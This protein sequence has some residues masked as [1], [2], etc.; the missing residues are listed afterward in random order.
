MRRARGVPLLSLL[1]AL[2]LA[3]CSNL[4]PAGSGDGSSS[5]APALPLPETTL[6][7]VTDLRGGLEEQFTLAMEDLTGTPPESC[8]EQGSCALLVDDESPEGTLL[9]HAWH[10]D[11]AADVYAGLDSST[12]D[13]KWTLAEEEGRVGSAH[14]SRHGPVLLALTSTPPGEPYDGDSGALL[15]DPDSGETVTALEVPDGTRHLAAADTGHGIAVL[16]PVGDPSASGAD[17]EV[18]QLIVLGLG[19]DGTEHWRTVVEPSERTDS[20]Y[21]LLVG[22]LG[23]EIVESAT[24]E[25]LTHAVL[26]PETGDPLELPEDP[27]RDLFGTSPEMD[28]G[29]VDGIEF[30][31]DPESHRPLVTPGADEPWVIPAA[32]GTATSHLRGVCGGKVITA[33]SSYS[34]EP[35]PVHVRA[36]DALS[37]DESWAA[38]LDVEHNVLCSEGNVLVHDRT[39][40]HLLDRDSG[41][42]IE[43]YVLAE[44]AFTVPEGGEEH[45][46]PRSVTIRSASLFTPGASIAATVH[47]PGGTPQLTVYR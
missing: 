45:G 39:T 43:E 23:V 37:G 5:P 26:A 32:E 20:S 12:G 34:E 22:E 31:Q 38:P 41:E 15:V 47:E 29:S 36:Y 13:V 28:D 3:G 18:E 44:E 24:G 8:D 2:L 9:V 30:A 14:V 21:S 40:A 33:E 17:F 35:T 10:D 11:P 6:G 27:V 42:V 1:G 19:P 16:L 7:A 4:A 46:V 25:M